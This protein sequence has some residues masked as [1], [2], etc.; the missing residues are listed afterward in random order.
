MPPTLTRRRSRHAGCRHRAV[1]RS[2][3]AYLSA[4]LFWTRGSSNVETF[5]PDV[6][7]FYPRDEDQGLVSDSPFTE[8]PYR[9]GRLPAGRSIFCTF[10]RCRTSTAR[11]G[12]GAKARFFPAPR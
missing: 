8:R 2:Y 11:C 6:R 3:R 10:A 9:A 5:T 1:H 4:F 12:P 7:E